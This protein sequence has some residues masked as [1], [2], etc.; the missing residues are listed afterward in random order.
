MSLKDFLKTVTTKPG[1][2]QMFNADGELLYVGKAKNLKKRLQSYFSSRTLPPKVQALVEQIS[3]IQVT[4]TQ[5]ENEALLL[6]SNL[7]KMHHPKY[8][9]LLRDDKSYPYIIL[10]KHLKYPRM[11]VYRG[12]R[13]KT[14]RYFGPYSSVWAVRETLNILQKLFRIRQCSDYFFNQRTRPCLQYQINR[15]T[16]PC[17]NKITTEA[18]ARDVEYAAKFLEGKNQEIIDVLAKRMDDAS[19]K[20]HYEEAAYF[21]DQISKL[22]AVQARQYVSNTKGSADVFAIISHGAMMCVGVVMIRSGQCVGGQSYFPKTPAGTSEQEVLSAFVSQYYFT[23]L[24]SFGIPKLIIVNHELEEKTWIEQGL[25]QESLHK[26][27]IRY[28][29]KEDRAKW[30]E[31][32]VS[33]A[34]EHL[35]QRENMQMQ[36]QTRWEALQKALQLTE[37]PERIECFDISH[38]QGEATVASCVVFDKNGPVKQDYRRFNIKDITPGDDYAAM[39]QALYRRYERVKRDEAVLP[40]IIFIDGG[41]G[42]LQQAIDVLEELQITSVLLIGIAKGEGRKAGLE[43]LLIADKKQPLYLPMDDA[44]FHLIQHIRDE[45]HRFAITGHRQ[46]RQKARTTSTLEHIPG[47][48]QKRRREL[49]R[50]FGGMQGL[51][52]A[53]A[54]EIATVPGISLALAKKILSHLH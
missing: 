48:G 43:K 12:T 1:I 24:S 34:K 50:Q 37:V 6:E 8:N 9:V 26:V 20:M 54:E 40:D 10:T 5:T 53:S 32:A 45:A 46:R 35:I 47:V 38:T 52:K 42:Q 41:K 3:N 19:A 39:H 51:K 18:Y 22:R 25:S 11:D 29:V 17:V 23:K 2:Y 36:D 44:G 31:M 7:I 4:V 27:I 21:R 30:L 49:L 16:A 28:R 33:N 14:A 13:N 15:C